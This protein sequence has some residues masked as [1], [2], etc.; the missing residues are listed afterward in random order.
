MSDARHQAALA[1]QNTRADATVRALPENLKEAVTNVLHLLS[2]AGYLVHLKL[3]HL[4]TPLSPQERA[5]VSTPD[6]HSGTRGLTAEDYAV[7]DEP[8]W[9][10]PEQPSQSKP[11]DPKG[12]SLPDAP[13]MSLDYERL[14]ELLQ[15]SNQEMM[16]ILTFSGRDDLE[17]SDVD[18]T[19]SDALDNLPDTPQS[20]SAKAALLEDFNQLMTKILALT[21]SA[22]AVE[23]WLHTVHPSLGDSPANY[24]KQGFLTHVKD[25]VE[26]SLRGAPQ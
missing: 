4:D 13:T 23:L 9:L 20:D 6:D 8:D 15:A 21:G 26:A 25:F 24:I 5:V 11:Q 18:L 22:E 10:A 16:F 17:A 14:Q 12:F 2:A 1:Q 3:E 19:K 7:G